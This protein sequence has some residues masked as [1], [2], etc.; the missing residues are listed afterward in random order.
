MTRST[1]IFR[2]LRFHARAHAGT[3]LGAGIGTAVL[4]GALVVGDSVR[5]SLR[6]M[7]MLR[8]GR[9]EMALASND[10]FFRAELS[11]AL[12]D[13]L[14]APAAAALVV[15]GTASNQERTA[16]ANRVQ[17]LGVD[18]R[19]WNFSLDPISFAPPK[20]GE[21]V[22]NETLAQQLRAKPGES[23]LLRVEKPSQLSRDAPMSPEE[24]ASL[25]LRVTV[26]AVVPERQFGRFSLQANQVP[27]FNAFVD[28]DWLGEQ[29]D[30]AGRANLMLIAPGTNATAPLAQVFLRRAW[31]LADAELEL[32]PLPDGAGLELRSPRVFIDAPVSAAARAAAGH[33]AGVLTYFVN[34][35]RRGDQATPYSMITATDAPWLP[36]DLRTDEILIHP[37]LAEDLNAKPG[38][39]LSIAYYVVGAMR[40]LEE[41]TNTFTVRALVM[42]N[43][44]AGDRTLMPDFPGLKDAKNC[45]EWDTGLPIDMTRIREKDNQYWEHHQGTPKAFVSLEAGLKLWSNRFG[46]LTAVR[47]YENSARAAGASAAVK[48]TGALEKFRGEVEREL[49]AR[50]EPA[51][52]G[53]RFEPVRAQALA[54]AE[55]SQD[56]GG[57]FLGFSFFLIVAALLLMTLLFQFGI[58]QRAGEIGTLLA[59]GFTPRQVR[60]G[61]LGEGA[62]LALIAGALGSFAGMFYAKAMLH[63]LTTVWRSAVGTSSLQFHAHPSTLMIG[64]LAGA[65]VAV[66]TIAWA[67]RRQARQPARELLAQGGEETVWPAQTVTTTRTRLAAVSCLVIG[68]SLAALA[69]ARGDS[70]AAGLFFGAGA[71]LL[72]A[73]LF[74]TA[75]GFRIA[76]R[77]A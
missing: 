75:A 50:L 33:T 41:R 18:E 47:F 43:G 51:A 15:A 34:E 3:L 37:W 16:R 19:F 54:A 27:P 6:D 25:A 73:G 28:R 70:N 66:F 36:S 55:Q 59:L 63:A 11:S 12:E 20:R 40:T 77:R 61:L 72:L 1:L 13:P 65:I 74:S 49:L 24:D 69:L 2:S 29:L 53:L 31:E 14:D 21:V 10:R 62:V 17:V 30:L 7:A 5:Q 22:L 71:L 42:T 58:E 60:L 48:E 67:L 26:S 68:V 56:F 35:I 52:V 39:K 76:A 57:L 64:A 9:I 44:P 45:R 38:D 32:R 46:N 8:L 23:V 4:V